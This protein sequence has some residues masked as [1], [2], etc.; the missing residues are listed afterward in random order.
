MIRNWLPYQK[1]INFM[2]HFYSTHNI[3]LILHF[4]CFYIDF[5]C[6][7]NN[8]QT[9]ISVFLHKIKLSMC[10]FH[11]L[12]KLKALIVITFSHIK[13]NKISLLGY[14]KTDSEIKFKETTK[15]IRV[16]GALSCISI[17]REFL[18]KCYNIHWH[19]L[20]KI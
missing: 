8:P 5:V 18:H 14:M 10:V 9:N 3:W 7:S 12:L 13:G 16:K 20:L 11:I 1:Y 17:L 6:M 19:K 4:V 15:L 2:F